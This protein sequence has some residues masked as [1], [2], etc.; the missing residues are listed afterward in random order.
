[1]AAGF[2]KRLMTLKTGFDTS[3]FFW[4][5]DTS[6]PDDDALAAKMLVDSSRAEVLGKATDAKSA[7]SDATGV[8]LTAIFK[9]ISFSI[10]AVASSVTN[11]LSTLVL[12]AG[13]NLIGLVGSPGD[14]IDVVLTFDTAAL[15]AGDL[16]AATQVITNA[17]RVNGGCGTIISV[18][19]CDPDDIGAGFDL[20]FIDSNLSLGTENSAPSPSDA[21]ADN[22]QGYLSINAGHFI[23]L[24]GVRTACL[25]G[26]ALKI[27]APGGTRNTYIGAV[28][29]GAGTYTGGNV[30]IKLGIDWD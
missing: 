16:A 15:A 28:L 22:I 8:G 14:V 23:D 21:D 17:V 25:T 3:V 7:L 18:T 26:Q 27:K 24:G 6:V 19:V 2:I 10:Q 13:E 1:M 11:I 20:V 4:V 30:P 12:A 5:S 29:R 9:Q